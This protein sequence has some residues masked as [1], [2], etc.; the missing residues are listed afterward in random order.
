M[1]S[2]SSECRLEMAEKE[3]RGALEK[4]KVKMENREMQRRLEMG[5]REV[6]NGKAGERRARASGAACGVSA[7]TLTSLCRA[8]QFACSVLNGAE[9]CPD[10]G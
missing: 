2:N 6:R 5:K 10:S 4:G 8:S 9:K 3:P 7:S 1:V